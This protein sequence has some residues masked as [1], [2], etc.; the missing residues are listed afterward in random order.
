VQGFQELDVA[1]RVRVR[2]I[3]VNVEMGFIDFVKVGS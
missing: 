3:S 1:E 2:L